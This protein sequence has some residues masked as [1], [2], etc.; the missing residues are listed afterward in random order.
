[1]NR[2][3]P[4]VSVI[5]PV[6][7]VSEYIDKCL[8]SVV[9]Q[10]YHNLQIII[11]DDGSTD[12]SKSICRKWEKFD[13]RVEFY[14]KENGGLSDARNY[15]LKKA[16]G[17]FVSFVDSDDWLSL[18]MIY[19]MVN[20]FIKYNVDMVTCQFIEVYE[21]YTH[22]SYRDN[23]TLAIIDKNEMLR[24]LLEDKKMTSQVW[25]KMYKRALLPIKPF[26]TGRNYEDI[27]S[28][29]FL[30]ANCNRIGCLNKGL[31]FYRKKRKGSIVSIVNLKNIADR[32]YSIKESTLETVKLCPNLEQDAYKALVI[33]DL[34]IYTDLIT[35]RTINQNDTK[36]IIKSIKSD[37]IDN[38][39]YLR[40]KG[41][42][43]LF[44]VSI[45]ISKRLSIIF[46]KL[47]RSNSS[48]TKR[49][50]SKVRKSLG[51]KEK[52]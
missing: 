24:Q 7:N 48:L 39:R 3:K 47:V 8:I 43:Y 15:G 31:Y 13:N 20:V 4:L 42:S 33:K 19:D 18:N 50:L 44:A 10:S 27:L 52:S 14:Q 45:L 35:S 37:L 9:N 30:V 38:I 32:Y 34:D 1:M 23:E 6:F 40:N 41:S 49:L 17:K 29:P 46:Y 12:N 28:M 26:A 5:I 25:R 22:L 36:P 2:E 11:V 16:K 51:K 21:G